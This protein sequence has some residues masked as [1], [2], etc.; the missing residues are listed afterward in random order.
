MSKTVAIV[1][2]IIGGLFLLGIIIVG[3]VVFWIYQNKDRIVHSAE[4]VVKEGKEFGEK[5]S[6]EG[7]VQEAL[8]R[9]KRDNSFT[10]KI[11]TQGFLL[12]CLQASKPS[13]GFCNGVPQPD[14][15]QSADWMLKKCSDAGMQNDQICHQLFSAV[16]S[17]CHSSKYSPDK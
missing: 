15:M 11:S 17:Y 13:Q 3:G 9:N 14:E 4:Q 16:Q 8:S 5:T 6:N 1:L 2:S 12:V 10:G 7:C